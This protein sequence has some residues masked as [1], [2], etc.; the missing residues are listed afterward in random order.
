MDNLENNLPGTPPTPPPVLSPQA[1]SPGSNNNNVNPN[2]NDNMVNLVNSLLQQNAQMLQMLQLQNSMSTISNPVPN[3]NIMPDLSKTIEKFN[4]EGDSSQAAVWLKQ[5]ES[6]AVLHNWPDAFIYQTAKSN[7][8]GAAKFW[9]IGRNEEITDWSKFK[10]AFRK[11]FLFSQN[12][13]DLWR[14]MQE[15]TQ[16]QNE[17]VSIYFHMKVSLCKSLELP[18]EE[19]KEQIAIGLW[20]KELSNFIMSKEH[21]DEDTLYQDIVSYERIVSARKCR[22]SDRREKPNAKENYNTKRE[23]SKYDLPRITTFKN[24]SAT[25]SKAIRCFNCNVIG[26]SAVQ[27]TQPARQK[28]S[29]YTC[30]AMDHQRNNC[31]KNEFRMNPPMVKVETNTALFV[32]QHNASGYMLPICLLKDKISIYIDSIVDSGSAISLITL[33]TVKSFNF[34]FSDIPEKTF[35]GINQSKLEI[36]G[37]VLF[38]MKVNDILIDLLIYVVPNETIPYKCLL[39]RDFMQNDK[40]TISFS[41]NKVEISS[42]DIENTNID[43]DILHIDYVDKNEINID[44]NP[45]LNN[46]DRQKLVDIFMTDYV[47]PERPNEPM[48]KCEMKIVVD[49]NHVPFY[50]KPRRLSYA[51]KNA[52]TQKPFEGV[53]DADH[54]RLW[55]KS[56][57]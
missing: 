16:N 33:D 31:P 45:N 9:F 36:L 4:G 39:G 12:K 18:F 26:H 29:C 3:F 17:N 1:N 2:P 34:E 50:Y 19:T 32:E 24:N 35:Q 11:T 54:L 15:C 47:N 53:F 7:L 48:T 22:I 51:E 10:T 20:S 21:R 28:G 23:H 44:I 49:P 40:L 37:S 27:C 14:K 25:R 46:L 56:S 55:I 5:I 57:H 30:G 41:G 13:T 8:E 43:N 52:V 38:K 42:K 6:T